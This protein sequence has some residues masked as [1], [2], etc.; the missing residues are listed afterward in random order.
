MER[1]HGHLLDQGEGVNFL[2]IC[3]NVFSGPLRM[4]KTTLVKLDRCMVTG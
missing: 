4:H 3:A 1:L 2:A